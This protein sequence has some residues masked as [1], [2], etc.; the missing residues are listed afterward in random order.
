LMVWD[1]RSGQ[2]RVQPKQPRDFRFTWK[3]G[4]VAFTPDGQR[5]AGACLGG[6][7]LVWNLTSRTG[8]QAPARVN[9]SMPWNVPGWPWGQRRPTVHEIKFS[10]D[11]RRIAGCGSEGLFIVWDTRSGDALRSLS[12]LQTAFSIAIAADGALAAGGAPTAGVWDADSEQL[13]LWLR[14]HDGRT[15]CLCQPSPVNPYGSLSPHPSCPLVGHRAA[16]G[17]I[18]FSQNGRALATGSD[19]GTCKLWDAATGIMLH[20][21]QLSSPIVSIVLGRDWVADE[22]DR[23][24]ARRE[25]FAMG[26]LERLGAGSWVRQLEGKVIRSVLEKV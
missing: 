5:I 12:G 6:V 25:A 2:V 18:C 26:Q 11:L 21:I 19:D 9:L 17:A 7:L 10:P 8:V 13:R 1:A 23:R 20:S 24:H 22:T 14:G 16:V 4:A 15:P 3:V